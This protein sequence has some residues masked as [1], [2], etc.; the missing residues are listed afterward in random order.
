MHIAY[1]PVLKHRHKIRRRGWCRLFV[2]CIGCIVLSI[3]A[4]EEVW[5]LNEILLSMRVFVNESVM[6]VCAGREV[7]DIGRC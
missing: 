5:L 6:H 2:Q 1:K 4:N 7:D 3:P